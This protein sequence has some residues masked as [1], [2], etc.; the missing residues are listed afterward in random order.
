MS[1]SYLTDSK[2]TSSRDLRVDFWYCPVSNTPLTEAMHLHPCAHKVNETALKGLKECPVSGCSQPIEMF[3]PD[4]W[5][6][7]AVESFFSL[8]VEKVLPEVRVKGPVR[9]NTL[10][11]IPYPGEKQRFGFDGVLDLWYPHGDKTFPKTV[12]FFG[13]TDEGWFTCISFVG[14]YDGSISLNLFW[15]KRDN[16]V[17]YSYFR[18]LGIDVEKCMGESIGF[19]E[20]EDIRDVYA[21]LK[22]NH[23][24][25]PEW[26]QLLDQVIEAGNWRNI[27]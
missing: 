24:F 27:P 23:E 17:I 21:I 1:S 13:E 22:E 26:K 18:A 10:H 4:S 15:R 20:V 16:R 19:N 2:L 14:R 7:N 9:L 3:Y 6:R 8:N 25:S 5:V 11:K 12:E